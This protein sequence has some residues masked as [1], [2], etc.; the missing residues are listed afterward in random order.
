[1]PGVTDGRRIG[2]VLDIIYNPDLINGVGH[3]SDRNPDGIGHAR[4]TIFLANS[5]SD[6]GELIAM[7]LCDE[8]GEEYHFRRVDAG[9]TL[10]SDNILI[11]RDGLINKPLFDRLIECIYDNNQT[12]SA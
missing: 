5:C 8:F 7:C 12:A 11:R 9:I 10:W 6:D 3:R 2:N 4:L 1:M